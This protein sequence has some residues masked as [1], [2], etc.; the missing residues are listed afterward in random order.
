M[1]V[2]LNKIL[3]MAN[4][5]LVLEEKIEKEIKKETNARKRKKYRKALKKHNSA[6]IRKLLFK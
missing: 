3:E 5:V 1:G 2:D 4:K 6:D